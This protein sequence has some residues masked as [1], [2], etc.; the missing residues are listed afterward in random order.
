MQTDDIDALLSGEFDILLRMHPH[1]HG[2]VGFLY[3]FQNHGDI[4]HPSPFA[5]VREDSPSKSLAQ[6][7]KGLNERLLRRLIIGILTKSP[8][9]QGRYSTPNAKLKTPTAQ[10]IN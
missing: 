9:F 6:D 4:I 3:R 5:F 7:L 1:P 8:A 2:R 10:L